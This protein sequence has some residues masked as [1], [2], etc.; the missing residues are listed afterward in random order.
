MPGPEAGRPAGP[1]RAPA[2]AVLPLHGQRPADRE[3]GRERPDDA[4]AAGR[5]PTCGLLLRPPARERGRAR[6]AAVQ[7]E[8]PRDLQ[9]RR[10]PSSA[11]A[12]EEILRVLILG[13]AA[14][15]A[16]GLEVSVAIAVLLVAVAISYRQICIAY[17]TGGGSYTVVEEEHRADGQPDRGVGAAH[18]LRHDRRGLDLVGGRADHL[19]L[20]EPLRRARPDRRLRD[21]PDHHRQPA[22]PARGGQHLRDPDLPVRR[23]GAA[24]DRRRRVPD[25]R[26][27]AR[28]RSYAPTLA[29]QVDEH[30]PA[31]DG[32][33]AAAAGVRGRRRGPDRHRGDRHRRA[34]LQAAR[35]EER[36]D[37]PRR[38]WPPCS[39]SSSSGSRSSPSASRSSPIEFP[40]KQTVISQVAAPGL[41]RR[42]PVLPLPGVHGAAAVPGREH[43]LQRLPAAARDPG[44]R[45]PHAPPVRPARRPAGLLVR[46]R[47]ARPRSRPA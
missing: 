45:R 32:D 12:T 40:E 38:S 30:G 3:G 16:W 42:R 43:Q 27:R 15:L 22:R 24:D 34:G 10:D 26:P 21:R 6:R 13:G 28:A 11:Y 2:C 39:A 19:G 7:E 29:D 31:A 25:R 37:D 47:H 46:D 14:A 20:P 36:R 23:V 4:R 1:G 35:G 44:R 41:R 18:R 5:W 8:G 17:P 33:P 9:L